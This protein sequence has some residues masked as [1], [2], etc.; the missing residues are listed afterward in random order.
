MGHVGTAKR[1]GDCVSMQDLDRL[2]EMISKRI[3]PRWMGWQGGR[4]GGTN[5]AAGHEG[6]YK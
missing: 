2:T 3:S 4:V 6:Q 5:L 1:N